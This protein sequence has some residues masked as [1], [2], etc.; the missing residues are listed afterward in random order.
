[1]TL[2]N[3]LVIG[4]M[5][6]GTTSLY[7][8][9]RGHPQ[10]YM[11]PVK[12]PCFFALEGQ[13][14]DFGGPGDLPATA[15]MTADPKAYRALFAGASPHHI[16]VGE[17]SAWYIV[18]EDAPQRIQ[19]YIPHAK[20]IAILRDPSERA[21]ASFR[22]LVR[23]GREPIPDFA[24]ALA[25][26][27]RRTRERWDWLWRYV[28]A[29]FYFRQLE[30]YFRLFDR[31]QIGLYLH[32]DLGRDANGVVR[33][34]FDFLEVDPRFSPDTTRRYN[35]SVPPRSARLHRFLTGTNEIKSLLKPLMPFRM[36]RRI[37]RSL[38]NA[39]VSRPRLPAEVRER[40]VAVYREDILRLQDLIG[41][42]LSHWLRTR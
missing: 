19:H 8:Y 34:I 16:A 17:A 18:S 25:E 15:G 7:E 37:V 30:R 11:S 35:A 10:I 26:E 5:S 40:L 31:R 41:R 13:R 4:A 6:S 27:D 32:E 28:E 22:H 14:L 3:F 38:M 12:E 1:M 21:Y 29:G 33:S 20:L 39:N 9:L 36:R 24:L 42:D 23:A 2:P